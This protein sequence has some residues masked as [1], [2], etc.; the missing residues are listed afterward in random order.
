MQNADVI[1]VVAFGAPTLPYSTELL[2]S[3]FEI[4]KETLKNLVDGQRG[5]YQGD[6][7]NSRLPP[8]RL[9]PKKEFKF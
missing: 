5:T 3:I 2:K 1:L 8:V 4:Y 9:R 6:L 7:E